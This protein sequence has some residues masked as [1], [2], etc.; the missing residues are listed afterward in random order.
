MTLRALLAVCLLVLAGC[1]AGAV[2]VVAPLEEVQ[3]RAYTQPGPATLTLYTV[4]NNKS[5]SGAHTGLAISASQ[6]VLWDPAGSFY[7]PAAPERN[8]VLF[9]FTPNIEKVYIDYH[10]RETFRIVEQTVTVPR[11][12]A[13]LALRLAQDHGAA[14]SATCSLTTTAILR[15]LPGFEGFPSSYFPVKTMENFAARTGVA[16]RTITDDDA[17]DNHGVLFEVT[18]PTGPATP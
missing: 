13:E 2:S 8:D 3:R 6:R 9:G 7:H 4:I 16:G 15:Q 18:R 17:D 5:G 10:A 12:V 11:E 1:G 14:G